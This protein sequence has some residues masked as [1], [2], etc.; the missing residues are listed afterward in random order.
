MN[1]KIDKGMTKEI[2]IDGVPVLFR[3]DA[4][5]PRLYRIHF[6]RDVFAD[7]GELIKQVAPNK[8]VE[9]IAKQNPEELEKSVDFGEMNTEALENIAYIMAYHADRENTADNIE[10]WLAQFGIM[11]VPTMIVFKD[12]HT[13]HLRCKKKERP[14]DREINTALFLLRCTQMGLNMTDLSL[15]TI[16]MVSDMIIESLNDSYDYPSLAVQA[17]FDAF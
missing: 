12:Q 10:D 6:G 13:V 14:I 9:E 11:S 7:M 5:I 15:L 16:G 2:M 8:N 4:S 1:V 17:D 3:A